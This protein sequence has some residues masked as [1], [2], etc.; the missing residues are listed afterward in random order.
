VQGAWWSG[1]ENPA[2]DFAIHGDEV[3]L[4]YDSSY[5]PCRIEDDILVFEPGSG[6][7]PVRNRI[8]GIEGDTMLLESVVTGTKT[9]AICKAE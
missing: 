7:G 9:T 1:P 6:Q 5:H 3:W 4:D 8:L 2:A